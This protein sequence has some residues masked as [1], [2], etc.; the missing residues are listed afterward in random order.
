L[1]FVYFF[2]LCISNFC[3]YFALSIYIISICVFSFHISCNKNISL[4]N[5]LSIS[6]HNCSILSCGFLYNSIF[7][8]Y[9]IAV[10]IFIH[11][12]WFA[13][14][15]NNFY[16]SICSC[17]FNTYPCNVISLVPYFVYYFL[18]INF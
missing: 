15:F 13:I 17:K 18:C 16:Y 4:F 5:L 9:Y 11:Y 14:C 8:C 2:V 6:Y 1:F 7:T 10:I 12:F 3:F